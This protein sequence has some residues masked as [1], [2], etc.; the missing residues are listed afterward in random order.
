MPVIEIPH[1]LYR[2]TNEQ[3]EV[4]VT[5]TTVDEALAEL[6]SQFPELKSRVL[7]DAGQVYPYLLLSHN[8]RALSRAD[9]ATQSLSRDDRLEIVA[10]A[11][12]G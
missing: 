6:W 10:L 2:F 3:E 9:F 11:E 8:G 5:A 7:T 4:S 12:G 1:A